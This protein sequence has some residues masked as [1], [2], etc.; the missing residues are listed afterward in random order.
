MGSAPQQWSLEHCAAGSRSQ[1]ARVRSTPFRTPPTFSISISPLTGPNSPARSSMRP[2]RNDLSGIRPTDLLAGRTNHE[3]LYDFQF[4]SPDSFV[5][6]PDGRYLFGSSYL[7]GASNLFRFDLET[8]KLDALTNS[9]TG[10]FRPVLLPDGS[11]SAFEY[12]SQRIPPGELAGSR[13]R[14]RQRDSVPGAI[15]DR[16]IP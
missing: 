14:G 8:K 11:L 15:R 10:L 16:E 6:S 7:T 1:I 4:N 3:V 2:E 5:F 13:D 9:E 12:S